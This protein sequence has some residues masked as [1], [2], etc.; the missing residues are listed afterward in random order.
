[1]WGTLNEAINR[2]SSK[3]TIINEINVKG[4]TVTDSGN[5]ANEFNTFFS[6]IADNILKDIPVTSARPED[7]ITDSG[8][9]IELGLVTT[10]EIIEIL[11]LLKLKAV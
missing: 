4:V 7:Y 2:S 6:E 11:S 5:I 3:S 1:M 8:L 9:N 10:D